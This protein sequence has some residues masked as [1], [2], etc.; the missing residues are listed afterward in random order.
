MLSLKEIKSYYPGNLHVFNRFILREYL[1]YKILQ[2]IFESK[3]ANNFSFLGGT[4]LRIVHGNSRFSEDLDFDSFN[5]NEK[6]FDNLA[7]AIEKSL[8]QEGYT[9]E[10]ETLH[11]GAYHCYIKFPEILYK[12]GLTGHKKEKILVQLD[13]EPHHFQYGPERF[14]LNKFDVFSEILCAPKELLL[15]QKYY[16][17][18]NRKRNK[19]RD[20]FD[21]IFLLSLVA[22]PDYTYL[23]QKTGIKNNSMLKERILKRCSEI[24]LKEMADDVAPFLFNP[25][26][27]K[28]II[29][30]EEYMKRMD[31]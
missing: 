9:V 4:A 1:Q 3:F 18:L 2:I 31:R 30:F 15:A 28:K 25:H 24:S 27:T 26:D 10:L 5:V 14:L 8:K 29:L 12:E 19:G 13:T 17:I 20:F 6:I 22:R 23:E 7:D 16:A 21:V 11:K